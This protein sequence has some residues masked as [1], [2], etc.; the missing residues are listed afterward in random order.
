LSSWRLIFSG[1]KALRTNSFQHINF[2]YLDNVKVLYIFLI[3]S[4]LKYASVTCH[5]LTLA[6]SNKLENVQ[7]KF[8]NLCYNRFI[9]SIIIIIMN[10]FLIIYS[11]KRLIPGHKILTLY[12]L[13]TFSRTKL[14]V[15][16]SCIL[17]V[18]VY[19]L[20]KFETFPLTDV[21][22]VSNVSKVCHCCEQ[23]L[24]ISGLF[25]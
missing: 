8:A 11:S 24:Q 23:H 21:S 6:E 18:S 14:P 4:K 7:R 5:N 10:E 12:L 15:V 9:Q 22:N 19:P 3:L 2:S 16:L 13:L 1:I 25:Q 20:S 17:L